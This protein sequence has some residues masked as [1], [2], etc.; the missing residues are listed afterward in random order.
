MKTVDNKIYFGIKRQDDA[1]GRI[2][3]GIKDRINAQMKKMQYMYMIAV[4]VFQF[5]KA[6]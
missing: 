4:K 1:V 3:I 5:C 6:G 2:K